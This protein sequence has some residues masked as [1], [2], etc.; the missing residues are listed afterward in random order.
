MQNVAF[1][2]LVKVYKNYH[3]CSEY[4]DVGTIMQSLNAS[5]TMVSENI[6]FQTNFR[7]GHQFDYSA[8]MI[9]DHNGTKLNFDV[10]E[11]DHLFDCRVGE[12]RISRIEYLEM[13]SLFKMTPFTLGRI[14]L[15]MLLNPLDIMPKYLSDSDW[16]LSDSEQDYWEL[17]SETKTGSIALHINKETERLQ[18]VK[19]VENYYRNQLEKIFQLDVVR[20]ASYKPNL[21]ND[22]WFLELSDKQ[23]LKLVSTAEFA[24]EK[25]RLI[26]S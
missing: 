16:S 6:A 1:D 2:L 15:E 7:R 26:A 20:L 19:Q 3:N 11:V 18:E 25:T 8:Q 24:K 14:S 21:N 9:S 13:I 17:K 4:Y 22:P 23:P 10:V 12:K 5:K